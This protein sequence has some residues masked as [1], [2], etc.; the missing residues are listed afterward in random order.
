MTTATN[1]NTT[2]RRAALA[3]I[4]TIAAG[5]VAPA[6]ANTAA[7]SDDAEL[8]RL[9]DDHAAAARE[10]RR[11][12]AAPDTDDELFEPLDARRWAAIER[13]SGIVATTEAGRRAKAAIILGEVELLWSAMWADDQDGRSSLMLS[14]ARDV[15]RGGLS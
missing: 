1:I 7:P 13:A 8:V 10:I 11:L 5:M 4:S 15:A 14:L 6:I 9:A 3:A 12:E 2:S